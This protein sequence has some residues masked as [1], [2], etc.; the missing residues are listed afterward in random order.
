MSKRPDHYKTMSADICVVHDCDL[1]KLKEMEL[2]SILLHRTEEEVLTVR[3]LE[4]IPVLNELD[5]RALALLAKIKNKK[6]KA[7]SKLVHAL[8]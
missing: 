8:N 7:S 5:Q 2:E 4:T 1:E 6:V 3:K